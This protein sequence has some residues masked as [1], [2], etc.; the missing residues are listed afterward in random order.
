MNS[1]SRSVHINNKLKNNEFTSS[2]ILN[3]L[4]NLIIN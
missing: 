3:L 2:H 4:E 1:L